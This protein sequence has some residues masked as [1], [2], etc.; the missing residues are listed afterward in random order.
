MDFSAGSLMA[1]LFVSSIGFGFF[2]FGRKQSRP[3]QLIVGIAMMG[4]P[5]AVT[6]PLAMTAVGVLL[7]AALFG[8]LRSGY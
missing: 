8:A 3:P 4:Y 5:Y 7:L 6:D 1:A 2:T